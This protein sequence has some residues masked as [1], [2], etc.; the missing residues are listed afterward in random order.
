MKHDIEAI[1][2][3]FIS[4]GLTLGSAE[5]YTGGLFAS[6]MTSISGASKFFKGALV[7]YF[8]EEKVRLLGL[9]ENNLINNGVVSSDT[10]K[11]M[12]YHCLFKLKCDYAVSFTGNA[13]PSTM[14]NKPAGLVYIAVCNKV[15]CVCYEFHFSGNREKVR[16]HSI[17]A[18]INIL[19]T[20]FK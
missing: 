7:T 14:E 19:K 10:A 20:F 13:G 11:E 9:D 8:T 5:S 2:N 16:E 12:A 3:I 6:Y 18:A 15:K 4:K 1:K 17:D